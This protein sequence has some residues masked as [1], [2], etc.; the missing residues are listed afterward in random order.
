M[1]GGFEFVPSWST[2]G[3]F[4][5]AALGLLVIPGPAVIYI[6]TRSIGQGR[7]AGIVSA[8]GVQAGGLVHVAA[9]AAGVS[10]LLASSAIAFSLVKYA[11]AMYL[12]YI[13][14]R[15]LLSRDV[16]D[17]G[18]DAP[19]EPM[20]KVFT[21]GVLVNVLN[22]KTALF[23]L[24]FLPQFVDP[25]RGMIAAQVSFLGVLFIAL[26]V[27]SDGTY[28]IVAAR[29]GAWLRAKPAFARRQQQVSGGVFVA[30]GVAAAASGTPRE[31]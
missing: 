22:P 4:S 11:G 8:L 24:A 1:G 28:A 23:F 16:E 27:V 12:V 21:R 18:Q 20:R 9:A 10:A 6:V 13:G 17:L 5:L 29:I 2:L 19:R 7:A 15:K 14:L 26:G 30:L 3:L 31:S 25:E